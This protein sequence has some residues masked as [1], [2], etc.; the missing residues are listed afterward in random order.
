MK[1][2]LVLMAVATGLLAV[3]PAQA[4]FNLRNFNVGSVIDA[5]QGVAK[6]QEVSSMSVE[7]EIAI[8]RDIAARTLGTYPLV[9]DEALQRY[10]NTVGLWVALQTEKPTLPWR[11]G[12]VKSDQVN[13]FAVPGGTVLITTGMLKLIGNEAELACVIGHEA[14]HVIRR[15][16]IDL[17]QK[18]ILTATGSKVIGDN[19]GGGGVK[20][21]L[22]QMANKEGA[23]LFMRSLDRGAERDADNDGVVY[24][25]RAGYDPESCL[26][27]MQRMASQ[28]QDAG[29]LAALYKTHPN[30]SERVKD[31]SAALAS[32][33]GATPGE[34]AR[35]PLA[36]RK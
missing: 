33:S 32:L 4:Q 36:Y 16:H 19:V 26:M 23:Q 27:L 18:D 35:P 28:K 21:Q 1:R 31:V 34:G 8:G 6:S 29:T 2:I 17:L 12:A 5:V 22:S 10:L 7:D 25:A 20:G 24:A 3:T 9:R 11:F 30:A 13:A 14:G 15:H